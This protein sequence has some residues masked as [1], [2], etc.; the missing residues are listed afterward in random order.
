MDR[1]RGGSTAWGGVTERSKVPVPVPEQLLLI[2]AASKAEAP[3]FGWGATVD[4]PQSGRSTETLQISDVMVLLPLRTSQCCPGL[5]AVINRDETGA[6]MTAY[7]TE[8]HS[9]KQ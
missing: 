7:N 1:R 4:V 3:V 2:T 8:S 9:A 6:T 5:T